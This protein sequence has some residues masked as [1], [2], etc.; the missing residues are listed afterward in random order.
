LTLHYLEL[1][2]IIIKIGSVNA[3]KYSRSTL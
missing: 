3:R 2:I 1:L